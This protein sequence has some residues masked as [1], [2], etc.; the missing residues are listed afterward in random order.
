MDRSRHRRRDHRAA[1]RSRVP[2]EGLSVRKLIVPAI[3]SLA[4]VMGAAGGCGG[5]VLSQS[6]AGVPPTAIGASPVAAA[7]PTPV[8]APAAAADPTLVVTNIVDGDTVD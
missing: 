3:G 5:T 6:Q 7:D 8:A 2:P 4:L 1:R